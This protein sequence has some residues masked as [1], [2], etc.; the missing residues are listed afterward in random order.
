VEAKRATPKPLLPIPPN[1]RYITASDCAYI[2]RL[3]YQYRKPLVHGSFRTLDEA[4]AFRDAELQRIKDEGWKPVSLKSKGLPT[5]AN[6]TG[7][8]GVAFRPQDAKNSD[9]YVTSWWDGDE[10]YTASFSCVVWGVRGALL[11]AKWCFDNKKN[12]RSTE[13]WKQ[14]SHKKTITADG[15]VVLSKWLEEKLATI[16]SKSPKGE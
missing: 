9:R 6:H 15:K 14:N 2:V 13:E 12:I 7:L 8:R 5:K 4:I 11:L 16:G 10:Q 3:K 1:T